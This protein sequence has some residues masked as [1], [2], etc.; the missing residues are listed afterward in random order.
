MAC[1]LRRD[2]VTDSG[3]RFKHIPV[4]LAPDAAN[5]YCVGTRILKIDFSFGLVQCQVEKSVSGLV[6]NHQSSANISLNQ[7]G[8]WPIT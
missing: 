3:I 8:F 6:D 1:A 4:T 5:R 7:A 2:G